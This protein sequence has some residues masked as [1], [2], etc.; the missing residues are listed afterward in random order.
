MYFTAHCVVSRISRR[1]LSPL[2]MNTMNVMNSDR[3]VRRPRIRTE[4]ERN[5]RRLN[6]WANYAHF[7]PIRAPVYLREKKHS[8]HSDLR[9]NAVSCLWGVCGDANPSPSLYTEQ[10]STKYCVRNCSSFSLPNIVPTLHSLT[11][12]A[13]WTPFDFI[14]FSIIP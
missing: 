13:A 6:D 2:P 14:I 1:I 12:A 4:T 7:P 9:D 11:L 10:V 5:R 3:R 8:Q